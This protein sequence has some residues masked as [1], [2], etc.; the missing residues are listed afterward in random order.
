MFS[1]LESGLA[2]MTLMVVGGGDFF[3][4]VF[5]F[6][7]SEGSCTVGFCNMSVA[8]LGLLEFILADGTFRLNK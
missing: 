4:F 7:I 1:L 5:L 6:E 8:V 3:F 2:Y